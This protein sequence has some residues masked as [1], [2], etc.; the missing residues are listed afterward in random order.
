[1]LISAEL[2]ECVTWF[3]YFVD[4]LKV[5]YNCAK[6][7]HCMICVTDLKEGAR[8]LLACP[9]PPH[10]HHYPWASPKRPILNRVNIMKKINL[11][12]SLYD[13]FQIAITFRNLYLLQENIS[14]LILD[15]KKIPHIKTPSMNHYPRSE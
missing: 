8:I 7:H 10:Y 5:R 4:L 3:I 1:M 13:Q 2:K 12:M 6:F 14:Y 11:K 9:S 15:A